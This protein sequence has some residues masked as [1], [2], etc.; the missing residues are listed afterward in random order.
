M[1]TVNGLKD[2]TVFAPTNA[3]FAKIADTAASLSTAQ[4]T[5]V[6]AYHVVAGAVA[7]S[8]GLKEGVTSVKTVQGQS[9]KVTAGPAGVSANDAKVVTADVLVSNGVVHVIDAVLLPASSA[10]TDWRAH[11]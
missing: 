2:I 5:S 11:V 7:Y 9:V 3:A 1:S 10:K 4:L 8:T 6:L